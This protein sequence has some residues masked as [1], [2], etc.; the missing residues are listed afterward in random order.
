[1]YA[2]DA[3]ND[4]FDDF[5]E[6]GDVTGEVEALGERDAFFAGVNVSFDILGEMLV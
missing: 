4:E 5:G 1:M 3:L 2:L 6:I